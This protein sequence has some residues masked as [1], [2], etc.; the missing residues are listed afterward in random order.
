MLRKFFLDR[1]LKRL[2]KSVMLE[3]ELRELRAFPKLIPGSAVYLV[4]GSV[5]DAVVG[6]APKDFD[7]VIVGATAEQVEEQLKKIPDCKFN[8]VGE[9]FPVFKIKLGPGRPELD[10]ALARTERSTGGGTTKDFSVLSNPKITIEEDLSRRDF[11][12]NAMALDINS[13]KL[14]DP[15]QGMEDLRKKRVRAVGRPT[16]R[17]GEDRTRVLRGLRFAAKL[18]FEIE[19]ETWT[20]MKSF[21]MRLNEK[22]TAGEFILKRELIGREFVKSIQ[23]D[24]VKTLQLWDKAA[25][26]AELFPEITILKRIEQRPDFHPE[27]DV[28]THTV[29]ALK[30]L[31]KDTDIN[32][33]LSVMFH[34]IGKATKFQVLDK[35][36]KQP[37]TLTVSPAEFCDSHYDPK[38][39]L[40]KNYDHQ[41]D[42]ATIT[43][44]IMKR[45]SFAAVS[46]VLT[47]E[48]LYLV[49]EHLFHG[50]KG[51]RLSKIERIL[52]Y[53]DGTPRTNLVEMSRAD[54]CGSHQDY[55][56]YRIIK[57]HI[58]TL[59]KLR[60]AEAKKPP[61]LVSGDDLIAAFG[62]KP[63]PEFKEILEAVRE[64]Q[65]QELKAGKSFTRDDALAYVRV[66]L[67][68][69]KDL[70]I[71]DSS[72]EFTLKRS[73][74]PL[75]DG[76]ATKKPNR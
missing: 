17:F 1:F 9:T 3:P 28:F 66:I 65:L 4:G 12:W 20:A 39:H 23:A 22:N 29:K 54:I 37:V 30:S 40:L 32:L 49:R 67:S 43:E 6:G 34:D 18:G 50:V 63:G 52:F 61:R 73:E 47:E 35:K 24:P 53:P 21:A 46:G 33:K 14:V 16:D 42:S 44:K 8:F 55:T 57:Q 13:G 41:I 71:R 38:K 25:V 68:Y 10:L 72:A 27:G 26:L 51:W 45:Y 59:I 58:K 74:G 56:F 11:T 7:L 15:F 64:N 60:E 19:K 75:N 62:L 76:R 48:V 70:G 69:A 5:R 31:P 36:T 2:Q